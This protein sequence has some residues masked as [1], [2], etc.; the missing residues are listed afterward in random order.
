MSGYRKVEVVD[1]PHRRAAFPAG[2]VVRRR[3]RKKYRGILK[4]FPAFSGRENDTSGLS[5][6]RP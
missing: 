4:K 6:S 2:D 5:R 3:S 1:A